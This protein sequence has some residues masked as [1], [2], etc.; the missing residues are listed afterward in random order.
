[1]AG[2]SWTKVQ[3]TLLSRPGRVNAASVCVMDGMHASICRT[4]S[5]VR[6]IVGP[7]QSPIVAVLVFL[8]N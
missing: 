6:P 8:D 7:D 1:M 2:L 4:V 5:R 3:G